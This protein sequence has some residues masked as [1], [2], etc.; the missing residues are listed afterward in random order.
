MFKILK[1]YLNS[2]DIAL[3]DVTIDELSNWVLNQYN[4]TSL[5]ITK[6]NK[7]L[8]LFGL[9]AESTQEEFMEQ[10]FESLGYNKFEISWLGNYEKLKKFKEENGHVLLSCLD[11]YEGVNLGAWLY[12]Q[13]ILKLHGLL[14]SERED[15][16]LELGVLLG[17]WE[18]ETWAYKYDYAKLYFEENHNLKVPVGYMVG[19]FNLSSWLHFQ[20][21]KHLK[22]DLSEDKVKLLDNIG[23]NWSKTYKDK[24][25]EKYEVAKKFVIDK[26]TLDTKKNEVYDGINLDAWLNNQRRAKAGEAHRRIYDWQIELLDELGM[27]WSKED[28][29]GFLNAKIKI[30]EGDNNL[31]TGNIYEIRDGKIE[32]GFKNGRSIPLG[33]SY[34]RT[35]YDVCVYFSPS[36]SRGKLAPWTHPFMT[37]YSSE[38]IVYEVIKE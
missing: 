37:G 18:D 12:R 17:P 16:L 1:K 34:F 32:N 21:Q 31:R 13:R 3:T 11:K 30:L 23:M 6:R 25:M 14:S 24:W 22:G 7:L 5:A 9:S 28:K 2:G 29:K 20:N 36:D 15:K 4:N 19:G 10:L 33:D 27:R 38:G 35:L 8:D 26:G